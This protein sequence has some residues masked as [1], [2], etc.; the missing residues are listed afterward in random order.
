MKKVFTSLVLATLVM[1]ITPG[2]SHAF[3]GG[4]ISG[5]LPVY[6]LDKTVDAATIATQLNTA[7]QLEA[8][9]SNLA[10][11]D[12]ATAA[13]NMGQIQQT[14]AQLQMLQQEVT[15][16]TMDYQT[17]QQQWDATYQDFGAYNGMS[18]SDYA[19]QAQKIN[20]ATQQQIYD[21]MRAQGLIS[22]IPGD[23]ASLQQLLNASQSSQGALA[24][25]QAGNQISGIMAQQI[26]RL[27]QMMS[28]SNQAQL[29]YYEQKQ[30]QDAAAEAAA[31]N[32]YSSDAELNKNGGHGTLR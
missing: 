11:M 17:F 5:P 20:Q 4:G 25:A 30:H 3:F 28:Q 18:G 26:M 9:L 21:A 1:N 23:A 7:Q 24:A 10:S 19:N 22:G 13:A 8:A 12:P 32:A 15:G 2:T 29:T 16:M 27:Q 31:A 14:L 6:N